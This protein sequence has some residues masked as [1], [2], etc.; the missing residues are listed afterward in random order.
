[1]TFSD[2]SIYDR[3]FQ[4]VSHKGGES[5]INY[6]K[7]IQNAHALSVSVVNSYSEDQ[8]MHTFLDNFHQ[9]GKYSAQIAS[10]QA[11]L[12]I[13]DKFTNQK[14]LN[15]SSLQTDYLNLDRSSGFGSNSEITHAV[16]IKCTFCGGT[17][18]SAEKCFKSIRKEK[19]KAR[20]VDVSDNR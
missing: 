9:G 16:Q 13:E 4:Q 6:T 19:D 1:M 15:F 5:A 20:A 12:R 11:D 18:L 3:T 10:H 7:I 8:L 2:K 17:N 14:L